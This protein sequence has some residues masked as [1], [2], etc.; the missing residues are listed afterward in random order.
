MAAKKG[1]LNVD[2]E[3]GMRLV[4]VKVR[5][6]HYYQLESDAKFHGTATVEDFLSRIVEE[7]MTRRY[8]AIKRAAMQDLAR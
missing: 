8:V 4:T 3:T 7:Y 6:K 2:P 1:N 5:P